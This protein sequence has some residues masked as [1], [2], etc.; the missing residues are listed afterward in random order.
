M[1]ELKTAGEIDAMRA[2]GR[3][4]A[5]A[6][7]AVREHARVGATPAELDELARSVIDDA[8]A[9]PLL[10]DHHPKWAPSPFPGAICASVN[11]ALV[12]GF[13]DRAK[14]RDGDLVSVDCGARLSGWCAE[15]AVS[16]TVGTAEQGDLELV[17]TAEQA[18]ADGIAAA[19]AG[20]RVGD[21]SRAVGVVGRTNGYGIPD[22]LGGHGVGR[23]RHEAPFVPNDGPAGKGAPLRPGLVVAIEPMLLAGGRDA[24]RTDRNGWTSRTEDGS[25]A[26]HA[27]HTIAIT[28]QGPQILTL[29]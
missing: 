20:G 14:L 23:Q 15:A 3:V 10:L 2:A 19:E 6:L 9:S 29:P 5:G 25:R 18:L 22:A 28:E 17:R 16:F 12:H 1:I 26:A 11:D 24:T 27:E 4:A 21:I 7:T 8:G 13:P